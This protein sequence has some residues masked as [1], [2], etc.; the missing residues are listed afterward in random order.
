MLSDIDGS[1]ATL[2]YRASSALEIASLDST[3]AWGNLADAMKNATIVFPDTVCLDPPALPTYAIEDVEPARLK[4][5]P[6]SE[7]AG[8]GH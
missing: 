4:Q 1:D 3:A 8:Q 5:I 7:L 2:Y 6:R